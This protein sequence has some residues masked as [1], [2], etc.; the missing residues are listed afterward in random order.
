MSKHLT[1]D[2]FE[3]RFPPMIT[4]FDRRS[5][6]LE[7]LY[8]DAKS[9]KNNFEHWQLED[10][11]VSVF[12]EDNSRTF[13]FSFHNCVFACKNP[14]TEHYTRDQVLRY[15]GGAAEYL[16]DKIGPIQ[17]A[18]FRETQVF[19]ARDFG[20]LAKALIDAFIKPDNPLFRVGEARPVDLSLFPLVFTHGPNKFQANFGPARREELRTL[21]GEDKDLPDQ[22]LFLDVDYYA[23]Q[24]KVSDGVQQYVS[25]FLAKAREAQQSVSEELRRLAEA[26]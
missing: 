1:R 19:P 4:F 9:G 15:V 12:D 16:G 20:K 14:P 13:S 7:A 22:A 25:Q 24:P 11:R 2:I 21:W 17:R 6:L 10:G 3:L 26:V 5:G 18:G 8:R 23:V